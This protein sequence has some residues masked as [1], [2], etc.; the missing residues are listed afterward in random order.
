MQI[1]DIPAKTPVVFASSAGADYI[2][3]I[4]NASQI[5]ITD[6]RASYTDG[7]PPLCFI[8]EEAGGFPPD[9]RDF[10]GLLNDLSG[11]VQWQQAGGP[12][13]WDSSFSASI[14]G[15]PSG[16]LVGGTTAG[17]YYISTVNNNTTNPNTGGAG[18]STYDSFLL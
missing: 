13:N 11:W 17:I 8:E 3:N 9:G 16:A 15:Y 14:G 1:T 6:G 4:P 7:F 2:R 5:G 12:V 18:W 10:N